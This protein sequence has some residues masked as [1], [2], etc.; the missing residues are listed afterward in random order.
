M[1][2]VTVYGFPQS[3]FVRTACMACLEKGASYDLEALAPHSPEMLAL[4]PTGKVPAFR[5]GDLTLTETS[6]IARYLDETFD[7]PALQP[8]DTVARARMNQWISLICDDI[9]ATWIRGIVLPR[10]GFIE[11]SEAAIAESAKAFDAQLEQI[12]AQLGQ[13]DYL[14]GDAPTLADLYLAPLVF[15]MGMTPEGKSALPGHQAIGR[16]YAAIGQRDSFKSTT[17]PMPG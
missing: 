9:Y 2:D 4:N 8:A 5:H 17:P 15:W 12:D 13:S 3:T 16:W 7:G 11:A 6:A 1:A 10:F 14:A